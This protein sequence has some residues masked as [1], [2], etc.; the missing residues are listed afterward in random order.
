LDI[1]KCNGTSVFDLCQSE[2]EDAW[3]SLTEEQKER[4]KEL[5]KD[6]N[7][8]YQLRARREYEDSSS[9]IHWREDCRK[10]PERCYSSKR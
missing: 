6:Y 8:R 1:A 4:Y 5:A 9:F 10:E 7:Q 3:A 2:K